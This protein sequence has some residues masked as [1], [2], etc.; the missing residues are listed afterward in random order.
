MILLLFHSETRTDIRPDKPLSCRWSRIREVQALRSPCMMDTSDFLR[1]SLSGK[2]RK[3]PIDAPALCWSIR[4]QSLSRKGWLFWNAGTLPVWPY[5]DKS[6]P[7]C[8]REFF[9]MLQRWLQRHSS[10]F[11]FRRASF[12]RVKDNRYLNV[13]CLLISVWHQP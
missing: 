13:F 10:L 4:E 6:T 9:L 3:R 1:L 12:L 5:R 7:Y 2:W 11:W 8:S